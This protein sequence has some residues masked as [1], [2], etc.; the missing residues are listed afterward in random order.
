MEKAIC[1]SKRT[2]QGLRDRCVSHMIRVL[3]F[4]Q[5]D[6]CRQF[7]GALHA[8]VGEVGLRL[9]PRMNRAVEREVHWR[10]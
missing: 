7:C 4:G 3:A 2:S 10:R 8:H 5:R 9:T 1:G 6:S